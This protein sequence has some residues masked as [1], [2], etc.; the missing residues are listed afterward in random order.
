MTF[1]Q[2]GF[3]PGDLP[4]L[5]FPLCV[6]NLFCRLCRSIGASKG[7]TGGGR[8]EKEPLAMAPVARTQNFRQ[9]HT[10]A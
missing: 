9:S 1:W 5:L 2:G 6:L 10:Y 7:E 3:G 4:P 8:R